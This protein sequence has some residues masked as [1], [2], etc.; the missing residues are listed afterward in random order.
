MTIIK[1]ARIITGDGRVI[2]RGE[3]AFDDKIRYVG[4]NYPGE[5]DE[6]IDASGYTVT[7]GLIDAHCHVGLFGDS[8]GFE[9][10][11]ANED[12]DPI[13][14]QLRAVDGINPQDRSFEDARRAG[15]TT[16]VTGPGSANAV[17]GQFAAVKT[18]GVCVDDMLLKAPCAMKMALGENPKTVY[19][20]KNQTPVTRMGTMALIRELL[21]KTINYRD[22]LKK[23]E[24]DSEENEKPDFDIKLEAMLPVINRE[25]PVK[26]HAHRA[27]DICSAI[28]LA[29]EF[30]IRV[31]IEHCS[32]GDIIADILER[33]KLPVMLG[34]TLTDRSKPELR[35]LS[36]ATYKNLSERDIKT[37]IIT[38]HP[39]ITIENLPLCAA[40]AVR[41]GMDGEKALSAITLTAAENCGIGDRVGSLCEGKDADIAVFTCDPT[42]F[43]AECIMTF[44]NGKA[45][46]K[47]D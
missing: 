35:N 1:N 25:I 33:E 14:P 24:D 4:E 41:N 13:M 7:P 46:Y 38:D 15:I 8:T 2:E 20:D 18:Y 22:A 29:K 44:I 47:K 16:V 26:V 37:A 34:P 19:N 11:D 12:S 45:V 32:D 40:L 10:A 39:E 28:R 36:F 42:D 43:G 23:Y 5:A 21:Y 30:D 9:G 17:G 27:D 6:V 3:V 31:T